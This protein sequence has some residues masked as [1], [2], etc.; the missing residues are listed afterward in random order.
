LGMMV[1]NDIRNYRYKNTPNTVNRL[2]RL[3]YFEG[4]SKYL[5]INSVSIKSILDLPEET[6]LDGRTIPARTKITQD[7][8]DL[9]LVKESSTEIKK[10]IDSP[11]DTIYDGETEYRIVIEN[12]IYKESDINDLSFNL[13][14]KDMNL[15]KYRGIKQL[16][17]EAKAQVN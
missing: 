13:S 4:E 10:I 14:N 9:F 12:P 16:F 3:N 6:I 1:S 11:A 7:D 15:P 2:I 8:G 17:D 5:W